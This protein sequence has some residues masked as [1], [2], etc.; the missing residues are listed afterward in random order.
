MLV[1][2]LLLCSEYLTIFLIL[3]IYLVEYLSRVVSISCELMNLFNVCLLRRKHKSVNTVQYIRK[4]FRVDFYLEIQ[5]H[6]WMKKLFAIDRRG[7][8][9]AAGL[10]ALSTFGSSVMALAEE[11]NEKAEKAKSDRTFQ[12]PGF[13]RFKVGLY[14]ITVLSDGGLSLPLSVFGGNMPEAQVKAFLKAN[15]ADA[16][17]YFAHT[18]ACLVDTGKNKILIDVG[19][20]D[21]FQKTTGAIEKNL[22]AAGYAL[23]DI[24]K[25]ILTHAHPDHMWGLVDSVNGKPRFPNADYIINAVEW[26]YWTQD[27]VETKVPDPVKQFATVTKKTLLPI[28]AKTRRIKPGEEVLPGITAI[29]TSGHTNGHISLT[30]QSNKETMIISGDVV[31]H[32]YISFEQPDWHFGFDMDA[33]KAVKARKN[34]LEQA[35]VDQSLFVGFHLPFPGVGR[36]VRK[37]KTYRWVPENWQ[38]SL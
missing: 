35:V 16:G 28:A 18:N 4:N 10:S 30:V 15:S 23:K 3:A 9:A 11:K 27:S 5:E 22:N 2:C 8:L 21:K 29:D 38:W 34:L 26:D 37:G 7:L 13:F 31:H 36:V 32:P 6:L 25:V 24:D 19:S 12:A 17:S 1:Y 14:T 20:G 33:E